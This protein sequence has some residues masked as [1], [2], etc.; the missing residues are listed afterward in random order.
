MLK[1]IKSG[2][3]LQRLVQKQI[4]S[5][6]Q[7]SQDA[8]FRASFEPQKTHLDWLRERNYRIER[9]NQPSVLLSGLLYSSKSRR[10]PFHPKYE[11]RAQV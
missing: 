10:D 4:L 11:Q 3:P 1:N 2:K 7:F 9:G 5:R 8:V 6:P